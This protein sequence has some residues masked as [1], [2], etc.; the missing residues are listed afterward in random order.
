MKRRGLYSYTRYRLRINAVMNNL[1]V[2]AGFFFPLL[3]SQRWTRG[4]GDVVDDSVNVDLYRIYSRRTVDWVGV[5]SRVYSTSVN[6]FSW[7]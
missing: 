7:S 5:T 3:I 6:A 4:R 2:A 1:N